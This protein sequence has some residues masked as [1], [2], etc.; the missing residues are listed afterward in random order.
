MRRAELWLTIPY[1]TFMNLFCSHHDKINNALN[2][3]EE[4]CSYVPA[5][6]ILPRD[7]RITRC[8]KNMPLP[9]KDT[10]KYAACKGYKYSFKDMINIKDS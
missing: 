5:E 8:T 1:C 9:F 2:T 6:M 4:E 7:A 3:C 10:Q